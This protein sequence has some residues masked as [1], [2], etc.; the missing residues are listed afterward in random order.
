MKNST[1]MVGTSLCSLNNVSVNGLVPFNASLSECVLAFG[2]SYHGF[3]YIEGEGGSI[4]DGGMMSGPVVVKVPW[5]IDAPHF[6]GAV[7]MDGFE[8]AMTPVLETNISVIV[9]SIT[10]TS[11]LPLT[12]DDVHRHISHDENTGYAMHVG[13]FVKQLVASVRCHPAS[14]HSKARQLTTT[15]TSTTTTTTT[16][17]LIL[18]VV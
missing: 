5:F 18:Q 1:Y 9:R 15:T 14:M 2:V 4:V 7:S 17:L 12:C 3:V 13:C 6:D 10:N 11:D 8:I 16:S